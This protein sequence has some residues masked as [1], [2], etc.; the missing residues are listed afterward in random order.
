MLMEYLIGW[1]ILVLMEYLIGHTGV[2]A[3]PYRVILVLIE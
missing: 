2:D 3:V 1:V